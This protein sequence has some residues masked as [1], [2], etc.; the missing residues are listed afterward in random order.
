MTVSHWLMEYV[1]LKA[2]NAAVYSATAGMVGIVVVAPFRSIVKALWRAVKSLDP[3]T[4]Y[5]I[6]GQL[7]DLNEK[8]KAKHI[9]PPPP[10]HHR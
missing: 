6:T 7:D 3:D 2:E 1:V 5:G 10:P 4:D 8:L 9:P